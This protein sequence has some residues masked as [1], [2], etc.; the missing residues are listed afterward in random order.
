M[1]AWFL[2]LNNNL[3]ML[4]NEFSLQENPEI[5]LD[6]DN[7]VSQGYSTNFLSYDNEAN[8]TESL[9]TNATLEYSQDVS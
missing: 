4:F 1:S 5:Y 6:T 9:P 8:R 2:R 3:L 7:I